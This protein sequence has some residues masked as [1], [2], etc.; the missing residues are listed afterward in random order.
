ML[1][2]KDGQ[3]TFEYRDR[4][5]NNRIKERTIPAEMFIGRFLQHVT[6]RGMPRMRHYG[7]LSSPRKA[8]CL[9]QCR[10]LLGQAA[11]EKK[12]LPTQRV[13][14]LL[15]LAGFDWSRCPKCGEDAMKVVERLPR[16]KALFSPNTTVRGSE[17]PTGDT[18]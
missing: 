13:A 10:A 4:K 6:P 8:K 3:V 16:Q 11:P 15:E 5:D 14:L 7:F 1:D 12:E 9:P 18:S 2:V 17:P